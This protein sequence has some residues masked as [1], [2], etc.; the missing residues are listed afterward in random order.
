MKILTF[1]LDRSLHQTIVLIWSFSAFWGYQTSTPAAPVNVLIKITRATPVYTKP[2]LKSQAIADVDKETLLLVKKVSSKKIWLY[3]EDEDGNTGWVPSQRTNFSDVT[4]QANALK[5]AAELEKQEAEQDRK[6][7]Q[8]SLDQIEERKRSA[9]SFRHHLSAL[10]RRAFTDPNGDWAYGPSYRLM[11]PSVAMRH[12]NEY[13]FNRLGFE[14]AFL[15]SEEKFSLPLRFKFLGQK[16]NSWVATGP[17]LGLFFTKLKRD[18][19]WSGSVGYSVGINPPNSGLS[20]LLR[21]GA[22]FFSKNRLSIEVSS[23]W[24]F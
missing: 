10:G 3:V 20:L 4:H 6:K 2:S 24:V 12:G 23:G 7:N 11:L 9:H 8:L 5:E 1:P 15:K 14:I 18:S 13:Q 22:E 17:D 19:K 16:E 21:G